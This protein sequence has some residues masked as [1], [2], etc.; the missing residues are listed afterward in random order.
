MTER[1]APTAPAP[2][3]LDEPLE[4]RLPPRLNEE[5]DIAALRQPV[6]AAPAAISNQLAQLSQE[7][8]QMVSAGVAA[9]VAE[10]KAELQ[11]DPSPPTA[12]AAVT[13]TVQTQVNKPMAMDKTYNSANSAT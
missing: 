13:S 6:A 5:V 9:A 12:V 1:D 11:R 3:R 2:P 8:K 4:Q 7:I 10:F